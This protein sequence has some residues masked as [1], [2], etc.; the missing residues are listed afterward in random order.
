ML[1]WNATDVLQCLG[2]EPNVA[3]CETQ[4]EYSVER[5]G[6]LLCLS[7]RPYDS[8]VLVRI[9]RDGVI[10][11]VFHARLID[12]L[13]VRFVNDER[14]EYLEFVPAKCFGNRYDGQSPIPYGVRISVTPG[15]A[16]ALF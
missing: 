1:T 9:S 11:P 14:G 10:R 8:D 5:D 12:C 15:I 4:F 2:V 7:I 16:V 3:E 6:L 13:G